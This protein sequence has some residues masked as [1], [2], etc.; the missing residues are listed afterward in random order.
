[1]AASK[2]R[3]LLFI[4]VPVLILMLPLSIYFVDS[5][6]ASD[7]VARNVTIAGVDVARQTETE[8]IASVDEYTTG[9]TTQVARV[10]VNGKMYDLDPQ[11]VGLTFDSSAAVDQAL[12]LRKDGIGD[13]ISAL[14]EEVSVPLA[15]SLD[16]DMLETILRA[17]EIDA[18]PNPAYEGSINVSNGN[19]TYEYPRTGQAIDRDQASTLLLEALETGTSDIVVLRIIESTPKLTEADI[20]AGVTRANTIIDR[21]VVLTNDEYGFE[22]RVEPVDLGRALQAQVVDGTNPSIEFSV[23]PSV[24]TALVAVV[25]EGFEIDP[26]DASWKTV[27]VDDFEGLPDQYEIK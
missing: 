21:G 23:N 26:V 15:A 4:A 24:I 3:N 22:F 8:A 19:V 16:P 13:W 20:D 18:I 1:M 25:R 2:S 17:W 14:S 7:K 11:E 12:R 6:A 9:L 5:A 10:E 27:L